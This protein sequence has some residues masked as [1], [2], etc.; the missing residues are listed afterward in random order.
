MTLAR[1]AGFRHLRSFGWCIAFPIAIMAG[2]TVW[3][4]LGSGSI[5]LVIGA[6][7]SIIGLA[8]L[9]LGYELGE[10]WSGYWM[11]P[12]T[13]IGGNAALIVYSLGG[14][15][16]T[17]LIGT[18]VVVVMATC[19]V[20]IRRAAEG[21]GGIRELLNHFVRSLIPGRYSRD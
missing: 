6:T 2:I 9:S 1:Y 3:L 10:I 5:A 8:V 16:S 14:R 20:A 19:V 4:L 12:V 17:V 18:A 11:I 21:D 15:W 13:L 7:I